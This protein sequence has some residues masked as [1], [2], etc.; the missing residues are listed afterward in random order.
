MK[1]VLTSQPKSAIFK[2][3]SVLFITPRGPQHVSNKL[4]K[5]VNPGFLKNIAGETTWVHMALP[6]MKGLIV[7]YRSNKVF[8]IQRKALSKIL[9]FSISESEVKQTI[10]YTSRG[11]ILAH[12]A[13]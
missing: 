6:G 11:V 9:I 13:P 4:T 10:V 1:I 12:S 2:Y 8:T 7:F 5:P 3:K